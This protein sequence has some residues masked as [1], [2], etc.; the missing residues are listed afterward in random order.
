MVLILSFWLGYALLLSLRRTASDGMEPETGPMLL[1]IR[2]I[3][4]LHSV[5]YQMKDVLHQESQT[6]PEGWVSAIPGAAS[7]VHWAT[8]NEALVIAEGSVEAGIDLSH[9]SERDVTRE[10]RP[11]GSVRL[12]V[13]LPP[14][15]IYPPNVHVRVVSDRPGL[16]W[17][18]QNI[19]PKAQF[20]AGRMFLQ[21]AEQGGIRQAAQ[22]NAIQTLQ[23]LEKALGRR[24]ID[25]R[26]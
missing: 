19:V 25:F 5:S 4:Q 7:A 14:V 8:H 10:K 23:A 22:T 12:L 1:A 21:S 9:L 3:G 13:H 6:D 18:D 24:N 26:F 20:R 2:Q 11:D 15:T 16:F 17:R